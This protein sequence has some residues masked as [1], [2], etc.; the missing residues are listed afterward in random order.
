MA[1]N[2]PPPPIV[3]VFDET[4]TPPSVT[5][6]PANYWYCCQCGGNEETP[7][8]WK[9]Y[10]KCID[11]EHTRCGRCVPTYISGKTKTKKKKTH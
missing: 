1:S 10:A 9:I 11:C 3:E 2:P 6:V 8:L 7:Q 5:Y 4:M